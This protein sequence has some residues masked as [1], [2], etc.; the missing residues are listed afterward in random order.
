MEKFLKFLKSIKKV[1]VF[2]DAPLEEI[3][4]KIEKYNLD[5]IQLHGNESAEFC[6]NLKQVQN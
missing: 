3:I 5:V 1:G 2:V 4:S 6:E